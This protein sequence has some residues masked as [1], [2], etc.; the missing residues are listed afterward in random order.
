[1]DSVTSVTSVKEVETAP[2][3]NVRKVSKSAS[4]QWFK[5]GLSDFR[6]APLVSMSY[7]LIYVAIGIMTILLT[8]TNPLYV[9]TMVAA[10]LLIGPIIAVGFYCISR[11][12]E[13][14]DKPK[15]SQGLDAFKFNSS[16]L[17][18]FA[19]VLVFVV[20]AWAVIAT[21]LIALF[22]NSVTISDDIMT[23]ILSNEEVL[24]F[25]LAYL[26]IAVIFAIIS[27]SISVISVPLITNRRTDVVTA[28]ITSIKA[29][30]KNPIAMFSWALMVAALILVGA[31][32][33][34]IGLAITLPIVGH[35]SWHAYRDLVAEG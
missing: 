19:L 21:V 1:M 25:A 24:P 6:K 35:A 31:Y 18:G 4:V 30:Q 17:I 10:F 2:S 13:K 32:F 9:A 28:M 7:G 11:S 27:F 5:K 23:T 8:W 26:V 22:F 16:S 3:F 12:I 14:G 15:F 33:F 29:V 34:Y 20:A